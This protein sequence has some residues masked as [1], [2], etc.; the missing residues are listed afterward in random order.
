M[1]SP[2]PGATPAG[3]FRLDELSPPPE[4]PLPPTPIRWR[5]GIAIGVALMGGLAY[6]LHTTFGY[7]VQ[8]A[9]GI[10]CFLGVAAFFSKSLQSVNRKTLLWGIAL[11][12]TLAIAVIHWEPVQALFRTVGNGIQA[13]IDASD[14]GADFVF[15]SLSKVDGP[16][17]FVFAFKALPPIIF[18]SSF[19]SVLY[20]LGVLQFFVRIMAK[21]MQ[22]MM[23]TSGAETL[24]V[25]ANVFMG[26]TESCRSS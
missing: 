15:G 12:F 20:Y 17:G 13:L 11:Q 5:V 16:A 10:F 1:I 25:S 23:G 22:Y 19:F 14:K 7:R 9:C 21:A 3:C 2:M 24:S 18:V 26:Q 4:I 8:A 6:A